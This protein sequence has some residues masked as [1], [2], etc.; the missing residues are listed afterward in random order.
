[1]R[2]YI[3]PGNLLRIKSI[4]SDFCPT[5][6]DI[7]AQ[8]H[9]AIFVACEKKYTFRIYSCASFLTIRYSNRVI[10]TSIQQK[11]HRV[12]GPS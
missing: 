11:L 3:N 9:D 10:E 4:N 1:M 5:L 8:I 7:K 6:S 2:F 12:F